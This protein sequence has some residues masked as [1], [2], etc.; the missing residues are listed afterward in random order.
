MSKAILLACLGVIALVNAEME[1]AQCSVTAHSRD[2][3]EKNCVYTRFAGREKAAGQKWDVT[4]KFYDI[5]PSDPWVYQPSQTVAPLAGVLRSFYNNPDGYGHMDQRL[6]IYLP[7]GSLMWFMNFTLYGGNE[8]STLGDSS[9]CLTMTGISGT[10]IW[11]YP[12]YLT[13]QVTLGPNAGINYFVKRDLYAAHS[14]N[15]PVSYVNKLQ[16]SAW[17]TKDKWDYVEGI[18]HTWD[19]ETGKEYSMM[20]CVHSLAGKVD[21][22]GNDI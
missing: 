8:D 15:V 13:P 7:D 4:C 9:C 14:G 17:K 19:P 20:K 1:N 5:S 21:R 3:L 12:N 22:F 6:D 2:Y 10:E 18:Q 16:Y 11:T